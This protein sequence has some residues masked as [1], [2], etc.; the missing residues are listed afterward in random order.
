MK[1]FMRLIINLNLIKTI[2]YS[3][4]YKR[5]FYVYKRNKTKIY[6][7]SKIKNKGMIILESPYIDCNMGGGTFLVKNNAEIEVEKCFACG[8][9]CQI[10][11]ESGAKL[12]V[13]DA[14]LNRDT[15]VYCSKEITIG[16]H[17]AISEGVIIRDSDVHEIFK[18]GIKQENT[19]PIHIQDNVW[20]GMGVIIL[21]GVTI[22][23]GSV[24]GA[25]SVV[26][27]SVPPKC[28]VAGNPA[29]IIRENI[30]WRE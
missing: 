16:K 29:K 27:R 10:C 28:L 11:I 24:I 17:V 6:A 26:T 13:G 19:K 22:G 30:E 23:E 18:D 12:K 7:H 2:F 9:N 20:I 4:K 21:K 8:A 14:F 5:K 15:K 25:A 3:I 1:K